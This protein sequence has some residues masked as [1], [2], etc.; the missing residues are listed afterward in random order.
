MAEMELSDALEADAVVVGQVVEYEI[1]DV[2]DRGPLPNYARFKI[3][4]QKVVSG[5]I[6]QNLNTDNTLTF[7]WDNST[8]GEPENFE[9][10]HPFLFALRSPISPLPPLRADSGVILPTLEKSFLTVL[11]A[12]C[13]GAFIFEES[14]PQSKML[15]QALETNRDP[16]L[17][18][19]ILEEFVFKRQAF[20]SMQREIF[21]LKSELKHLQP[22]NDDSP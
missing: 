4:V 7:T 17:E 8:F 2:G 6:S 20:S 15:Q 9:H 12:P 22:A 21:L 14:S 16:T 18:L 10:R 19:E 5:D 1:V 13:A 11:Q 3:D